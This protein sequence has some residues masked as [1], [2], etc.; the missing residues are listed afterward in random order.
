MNAENNNRQPG[1][2]A[3]P[4]DV[5]IVLEGIGTKL[6]VGKVCALDLPA[7]GKRFVYVEEM[8]DGR[9]RLTY[10][11]SL[12]P[13][14]RQLRALRLVRGDLERHEP[15][16]SH[17]DVPCFDCGLMLPLAIAREDGRFHCRTCWEPCLTNDYVP[18]DLCREEDDPN[19][20]A[21]TL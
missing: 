3:K 7:I 16:S 17:H 4:V 21:H 10:T 15:G 9:W 2:A 18:D 20:E 8:P 1:R 12:I 6:R 13:D 19:G 5:S 14:I 11:K